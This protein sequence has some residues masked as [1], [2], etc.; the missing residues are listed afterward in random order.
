MVVRSLCKFFQAVGQSVPQR[1]QG[2]LDG[3]RLEGVDQL[4]LSTFHLHGG[5]LTLLGFFGRCLLPL[6]L[7]SFFLLLCIFLCLLLLR[8]LFGF[9]DCQEGGLPQLD[10]HL[11][12]A[13]EEALT[14]GLAGQSGHA[15]QLKFPAS[16]WFG[17]RNQ[18][19]SLLGEP[20]VEGPLGLPLLLFLFVEG[21]KTAG[22]LQVRQL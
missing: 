6:F 8:L 17:W 9:L 19:H 15:V 21:R 22:R 18:D 4:L 3:E 5:G 16:L 7:F 1:V 14:G 10:D 11:Q 20:V 13:Q 12:H 2:E